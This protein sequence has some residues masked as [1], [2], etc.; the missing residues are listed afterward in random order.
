[1][2][3]KGKQYKHKSIT[4][5]TYEVDVVNKKDKVVY[6]KDLTHTGTARIKVTFAELD[7]MYKEA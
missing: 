5:T 7:R 4:D 6:L 3:V 1:M 2:T